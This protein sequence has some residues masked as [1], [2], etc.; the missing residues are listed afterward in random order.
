MS[1]FTSPMT[2]ITPASRS[3]RPS[4][5][6]R[7]QPALRS[8][9]PYLICIGGFLIAWQILSLILGVAAATPDRGAVMVGL[10][11]DAI[12]STRS[13]LVQLNLAYNQLSSAVSALMHTSSRY[14]VPATFVTTRP[15]IP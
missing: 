5:L 6:R 11:L 1:S 13:G 8:L 4:K 14:S 15:R 9:M 3:K 7:L 10:A 12:V 2:A